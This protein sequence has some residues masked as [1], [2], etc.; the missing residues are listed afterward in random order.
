MNAKSR[1]TLAMGK[2]VLEFSRARPDASPGYTAALT[3]LQQALE[4]GDHSADQQRTGLLESRVA[5]KRKGEVKRTL[6]QAHL[7]HLIGVARV[8]AREVPE[9]EQKF[10]M[11]PGPRTYTAFVTAARG[12]A[13]EAVAR[14]E[15]LVKHGLAESVLNDLLSTLDQFDAAEKQSAAARQTHVGASADLRAIAKEVADI[16]AVMDGLNRFRFMHDVESLAA[17]E[18]ARNIATAPARQPGGE[19]A[20]EQPPAPG[21]EA[22]PAA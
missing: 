21:S 6:T 17:W 4:R 5:T 10:V 3:A 18:S 19:P 2:A 12:I 7:P 1:K 22:R 14:K 13:S 9:L 15:L 20:P 8:A 16:V 11:K